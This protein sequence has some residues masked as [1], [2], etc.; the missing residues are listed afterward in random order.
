MTRLKRVRPG[1]KHKQRHG[2]QCIAIVHSQGNEYFLVNNNDD[3]INVTEAFYNEWQ[4]RTEIRS[5]A[6]SCSKLYI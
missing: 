1:N 3:K 2:W 6:K 5:E 4:L